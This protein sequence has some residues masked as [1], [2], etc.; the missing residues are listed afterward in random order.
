MLILSIIIPVYNVEKYIERCLHSIQEQKECEYEVLLVDDES[1]DHTLAIAREV[2]KDFPQLR[3]LEQE[4]AGQAKARNLALSIAQGKYVTFLDGDD[5][6]ETDHLK[7]LFYLLSKEEPDLLMGNQYFVD[8]NGKKQKVQCIKQV[9]A[10]VHEP[11]IFLSECVIIGS[12]WLAVCNREVI[13]AYQIRFTEEYCC[14]EDFDFI[15]KCLIHIKRAAFMDWVY[16]NYFRDNEGSTY[17]LL[18]GEKIKIYMQ[19][20]RKW[21]DY[22]CQHRLEFSFAENALCGITEHAKWAFQQMISFPRKDPMYRELCVYFSECKDVLGIAPRKSFRI[23]LEKKRFM[24]CLHKMGHE[25]KRAWKVR[26]A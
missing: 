1:T 20:C 18:S 3:I 4:H 10:G 14:N 23:M 21:Y 6:W 16:Y 22:F 19:V 9:V 13:E 26:R 7:K 8:E 15:L 17:N 11:D 5:Y 24:K 12:M 25:V 2:Q